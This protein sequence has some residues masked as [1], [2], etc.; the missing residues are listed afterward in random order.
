MPAAKRKRDKTSTDDHGGKKSSGAKTGKKKQAKPGQGVGGGR[1]PG[2]HVAFVQSPGS[3][4]IRQKYMLPGTTPA[5]V[6]TRKGAAV[7]PAS[8]ADSSKIES[9]TKLSEEQ[10]KGL[11]TENS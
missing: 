9:M 6:P 2:G 8:A 4:V 7:V 5:T 1:T 10:L 3:G 11:H